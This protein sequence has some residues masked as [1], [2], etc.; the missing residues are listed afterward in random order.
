MQI[1][2]FKFKIFILQFSIIVFV[3][4][5][6]LQLTDQQYCIVVLIHPITNRPPRH[7]VVDLIFEWYEANAL[8]LVLVKAST[9]GCK[10]EHNAQTYAIDVILFKLSS[11]C[12][13]N[14]HGKSCA[15]FFIIRCWRGARLD[16]LIALM[17]GKPGLWEP[18]NQFADFYR[19]VYETFWKFFRCHKLPPIF[20]QLSFSLFFKTT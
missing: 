14:P 15:S 6:L 16:K 4:D 17:S 18:F 2:N 5:L 12:G 20:E 11:V 9:N 1:S 3:S 13:W 19:E 8:C 7:Q 10:N